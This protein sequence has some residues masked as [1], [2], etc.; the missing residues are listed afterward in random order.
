[1]HVRRKKSRKKEAFTPMK[2]CAEKCPI[3]IGEKKK[4]SEICCEMARQCCFYCMEE[5]PIKEEYAKII[6]KFT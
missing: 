6:K 2:G 4:N 5:C 1:M 3:L